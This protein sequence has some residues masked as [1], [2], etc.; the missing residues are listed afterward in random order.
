MLRW[1]TLCYPE[2]CCLWCQSAL[3]FTDD[4]ACPVTTDLILRVSVR[5][6]TTT[7]T[8]PLEARNLKTAY[9]V[10]IVDYYR[11]FTAVPSI[12]RAHY[13]YSRLPLCHRLVTH[14]LTRSRINN[15]PRIKNPKIRP[16]NSRMCFFPPV[17]STRSR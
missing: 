9:Q 2:R 14:A 7:T 8:A 15:C 6:T 12:A 11:L 1:L 10:Y 13:C 5:T 16:R 17:C 4:G 3:L